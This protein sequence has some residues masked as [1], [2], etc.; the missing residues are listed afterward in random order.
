MR[1][2]TSG[3]PSSTKDYPRRI[4]ASE[5]CV[6]ASRAPSQSRR[7]TCGWPF[8]ARSHRRKAGGRGGLSSFDT[9]RQKT[10]AENPQV[11]R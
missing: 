11:N 7:R 9:I 10:D 8:S 2:E 1:F 4:N 5:F 3:E 6:E